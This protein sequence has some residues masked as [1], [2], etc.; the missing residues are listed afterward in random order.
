MRALRSGIRRCAG[1]ATRFGRAPAGSGSLSQPRGARSFAR[2]MRNRRKDLAFRQVK[3]PSGEEPPP[4]L[5]GEPYVEPTFE[6][7]VFNQVGERV[8]IVPL[9][10]DIFSTPLRRDILQNNVVYRQNEALGWSRKKTLTRGEIRGSNKKP[11]PQKGGGRARQGVRK[12]TPIQIG[13]GKAHGPK[14]RDRSTKLLKKVKQ[15]GNRVVVAQK[16]RENR[17]TVIDN[18]AFEVHKTYAA[19][20]FVDTFEWKSALFVLEEEP[21]KNFELA[22]RNLPD[23]ETTSVYKFNPYKALKRKDIVISLAA[24]EQLQEY[25]TR[26]IRPLPTATGEQPVYEGLIDDGQPFS[27]EKVLD[28]FPIYES[29]EEVRKRRAEEEA[30]MTQR[31]ADEPRPVS[32]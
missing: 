21:D 4:P 10:A 6:S 14:P 29:V 27:G 12:K 19:K 5:T 32:G 31:E 7:W 25:L 26:N 30:E 2:T 28:A 22:V 18:L 17:F 16:F 24:L 15:L 11:F 1:I 20:K 9:N 8:G 3:R 13:G 23:I